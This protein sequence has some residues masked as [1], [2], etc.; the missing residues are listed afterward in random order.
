MT[1]ITDTIDWQEEHLESL[2]EDSYHVCDWWVK[3]NYFNPGEEFNED[4]RDE[5]TASL[6]IR[7]G[8]QEIVAESGLYD[9][10]GLYALV[11][12]KNV[13]EELPDLDEPPAV[14]D[15]FEWVRCESPMEH[16]VEGIRCTLCGADESFYDSTMPKSKARITPWE[17]IRH[18]PGCAH[19]TEYDKQVRAEEHLASIIR[20]QRTRT[21]TIGALWD[22]AEWLRQ[23]QKS[24]RAGY[25]IDPINEQFHRIGKTLKSRLNPRY[26]TCPECG[27]ADWRIIEGGYPDECRNCYTRADE[28]VSEEYVKQNRRL[29][30]WRGH[31]VRSR[32]DSDE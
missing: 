1:N 27:E 2:D 17:E 23:L 10:S 7:D 24:D 20:T 32:G 9:F 16:H 15:D 6:I 26:P 5:R 21:M 4:E 12:V 8:D 22:E 30:G 25:L 11:R 18:N 13:P 19:A 3:E 29:W 28:A 31:G 14:P